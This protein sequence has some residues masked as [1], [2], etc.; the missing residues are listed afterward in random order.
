MVDDVISI[1]QA[2]ELSLREVQ[3]LSQLVKDKVKSRELASVTS[4]SAF[5]L[6]SCIAS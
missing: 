5:F 2:R 4:K 3:E 1:L 6:P